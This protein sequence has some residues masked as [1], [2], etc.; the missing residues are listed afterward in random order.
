MQV[1]YE[2]PEDTG[3]AAP[4]GEAEAVAPAEQDGAGVG[5]PSPAAAAPAWQDSEEFYDAVSATVEE[6]LQALFAE[7]QQAQQPGQPGFDVNEWDPTDPVSF[8][9]FL[10]ARDQHILQQMQQLVAP[11]QQAAQQQTMAE[12][13]ERLKDVL[14][15]VQVRTGIELNP[16]LENLARAVARDEVLALQERMGG[17]VADSHVERI[18]E[19]SVRDIGATLNSYA[20]DYHNRK[21]NELNAASG[22]GRT[23]TS[24]AQ[25]IEVPGEYETEM[26]AARAFAARLVTN[27]G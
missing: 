6:R 13:E 21:L 19:K 25:G 26:D 11:L 8:G 27:N 20:E 7:Q 3:A 15:D 22:A 23:V 2:A 1:F 4:A 16:S 9:N 10:Q 17:T 18:I 12:A 14:H 5:T 24:G